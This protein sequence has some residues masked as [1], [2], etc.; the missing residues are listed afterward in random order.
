MNNQFRVKCLF[1]I[2]LITLGILILA[3]SLSEIHFEPGLPIPGAETTQTSNSEVYE[4]SRPAIEFRLIFQ[5]PLAIMFFL[6]IIF[7][8][9]SLIK[10]SH[11]VK[12][13]KL[14]IGLIIILCIFLILDQINFKVP[15]SIIGESQDIFLITPFPIHSAPIGNP[16]TEIFWLVIVALVIGTLSTLCLFLFRGLKQTNKNDLIAKEAD[17]A[18]KDIKSG[19]DLR[20]TIIRCY[21]H[22]LSIM[23]EEQGIK[24]LNHETPREFETI[25]TAKGIPVS[26]IHQLTIL[27]E[28]VRYGSKPTNLSDENSAIECL[29]VIRDFF[30]LQEKEPK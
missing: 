7:L 28:K 24:R 15:T 8:I 25:L 12:I 20:N 13:I 4:S 29:S 18:I 11:F 14:S 6:I 26:T 21:I 19:G 1:Y 27:F 2:V 30:K 9:S 5:L 16:P 10:K 17:A 22:M 3:S 23:E